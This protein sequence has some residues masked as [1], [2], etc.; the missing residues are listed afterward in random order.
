MKRETVFSEQIEEEGRTY[1]VLIRRSGTG[2]KAIWYSYVMNQTGIC[3]EM[4]GYPVDQRQANEPHVYTPEEIMDMARYEAYDYIS[5]LK[6]FEQLEDMLFD[7][8]Y[9]VDENRRIAK[10]IAE[11]NSHSAPIP[12]AKSN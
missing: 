4:S 7:F 9:E 2:I 1:T 11:E 3:K 6:R 5:D 10:L 8:M 12:N